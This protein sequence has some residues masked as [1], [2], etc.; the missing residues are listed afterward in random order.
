MS[1]ERGGEEGVSRSGGCRET[2]GKTEGCHAL[3]WGWGGDETRA[4]GRGNAGRKR[5]LN[6]HSTL[7]TIYTC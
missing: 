2:R 5:T 4:S 6:I 3:R 7:G 1:E